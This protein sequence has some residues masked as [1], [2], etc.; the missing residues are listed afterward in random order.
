MSVFSSFSF[1]FRARLFLSRILC[2]T[3][4]PRIHISEPD[5]LS[6]GFVSLA[7]ISCV[8]SVAYGCHLLSIDLLCCLPMS[9]CII[10]F[11]PSRHHSPPARV[12]ACCSRLC[13][14][15]CPSGAVVRSD[16]APRGSATIQPPTHITKMTPL[17]PPFFTDMM[18][19]YNVP[20]RLVRLSLRR[21][22]RGRGKG[23]PFCLPHPFACCPLPPSHAPATAA[24]TRPSNPHP[25]SPPC[26]QHHWPI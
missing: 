12:P 5:S 14:R 7:K 22:I 20:Q 2:P 26:P 10:L 13:S 21:H 25:W 17:S 11:P 16:A 19:W 23:R 1:S 15:P 6:L 4:E 24:Q 18:T 3:L 9:V 8:C